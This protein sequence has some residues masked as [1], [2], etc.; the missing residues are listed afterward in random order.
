MKSYIVDSKMRARIRSAAQSID[1][2]LSLG[3]NALRLSL[4]VP[5]K[6]TWKS[7]KS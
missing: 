6:N 4:P 7:M 3:K 5:W 2:V 1:S